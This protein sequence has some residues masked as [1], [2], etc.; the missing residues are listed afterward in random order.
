VLSAAAGW[1]FARRYQQTRSLLATSIEHALYGVL[2]FT[3]GL[4]DLFYHGAVGR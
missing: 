4:G 3:V 2:A 1:I